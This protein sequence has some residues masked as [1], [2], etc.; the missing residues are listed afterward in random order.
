MQRVKSLAGAVVLAL[1]AAAPVSLGPFRD[2]SEAPDLAAEFVII[3]GQSQ[4]R[5]HGHAF[6]HSFV[7]TTHRV[8]GTIRGNP[9]HLEDTAAVELKADAASFDSGIQDR[10]RD[11]AKAIG[12][13][14]YPEIVFVSEKVQ[15]Q[16]QKQVPNYRLPVKI[17][18]QL[19]LHGQTRRL[20]APATLGFNPQ[21][22]T[23]S[24]EGS[25][26][27]KMT[28]FGVTLPTFLFLTVDDKFEIDFKITARLA[29]PRLED[30]K[31]KE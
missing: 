29:S 17:V 26:P 13:D 12:A 3:P 11:G 5:Y 27:V 10:D 21:D 31:E 7:G 1:V 18:G 30:I 24:A 25:F 23:M 16:E 2:L 4:L 28:D 19:T 9:R 15:V 20:E 6:L 14:R 8:S 22:R